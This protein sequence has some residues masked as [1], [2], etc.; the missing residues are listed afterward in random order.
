MYKYSLLLSYTATGMHT[1]DCRTRIWG[2]SF[3]KENLHLG[4]KM[5]EELPAENQT[6][7]M[8]VS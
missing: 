7:H 2:S 1:S 4:K 5:L 3:V 6:Q 8:E